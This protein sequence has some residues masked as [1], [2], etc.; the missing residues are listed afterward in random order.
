M[1][2]R[3]AD[4]LLSVIR[5]SVETVT[6]VKGLPAVYEVVDPIWTDLA[7]AKGKDIN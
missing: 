1:R 3:S 6:I 4:L 2:I 7:K 5:L